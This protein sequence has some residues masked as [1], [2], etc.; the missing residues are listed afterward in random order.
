MW[1]LSSCDSAFL[2]AYP[3]YGKSTDPWSRCA[4]IA[5]SNFSCH[6]DS[7]EFIIRNVDSYIFVKCQFDSSTDSWRPSN[8]PVIA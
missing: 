4:G 8:R 1:Q 6:I 3:L 5:G 2:L 7:E